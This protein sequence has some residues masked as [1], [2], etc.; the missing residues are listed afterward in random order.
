MPTAPA[1]DPALANKASVTARRM[2][3][4]YL[5]SV[6]A[7]LG[8]TILDVV[9]AAAQPGHGPLLRISLDQLL[10]AQEGWGQVRSR[11][12]LDRLLT[13]CGRTDDR[14]AT[15]RL[16]IGWLLD[17]R[18]AGGRLLAFLDVTAT[19][20]GVPWRGFPYTPAPAPLTGGERR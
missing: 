14:V 16:D 2:R 18:A 7:G 9:A 8:V 1:V 5:Q 20:K 15:T 3:A 10:R 17:P 11:A 13:F 4:E 19:G 12:A 6:T